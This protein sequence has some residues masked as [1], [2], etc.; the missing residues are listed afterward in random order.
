[1]VETT[2]YVGRIRLGDVKITIRPKLDAMPLLQLMR[3]AFAV[4]ALLRS[5]FLVLGSLVGCTLHPVEV[6]GRGGI[7]K[8]VAHVEHEF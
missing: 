2:S 5:S 7:P 4:T 8:K 1:M 3:Y 6:I